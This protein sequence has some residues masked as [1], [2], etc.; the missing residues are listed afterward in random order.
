MAAKVSCMNSAPQVLPA[1][2][3]EPANTRTMPSALTGPI[4]R[5]LIPASRKPVGAASGTSAEENADG[6]ATG[7]RSVLSWPGSIRRS[8]AA[9]R[10]PNTI[11]PTTPWTHSGRPSCAQPAPIRPP[12]TAPS[13]HQ[14]W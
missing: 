14:P 12:T 10:A 11:M 3:V 9:A 5:R 13:D 8:E 4:A 1:S 2:S 7:A 6:A